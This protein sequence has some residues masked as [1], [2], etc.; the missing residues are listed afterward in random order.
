MSLL[1]VVHANPANTFSNATAPVHFESRD[2]DLNRRVCSR[3]QGCERKKAVEKEKTVEDWELGGGEG[4]R[5]D[6]AKGWRCMNFESKEDGKGV[7]HNATIYTC[8]ELKED[9]YRQR[10][11]S[12]CL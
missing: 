10:T 12:Q 9:E 7:L 6:L 4:L 1:Q 11:I 3:F 2:L 5:N 8:I